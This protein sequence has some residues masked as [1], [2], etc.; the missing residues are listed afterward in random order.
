MWIGKDV[1]RTMNG[2][3]ESAQ[4]R[5]TDMLRRE[6]ALQERIAAL[7]RENTRQQSLIEWMKLRLNAVEKER[8]QLISAAIGVKVAIPEFV[9]ANTVDQMTSALNE[10][11]DLSTVGGDA[12][13]D[14]PPQSPDEPDYSQMPGYRG[15]DKSWQ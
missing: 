3:I 2:L 9:P 5:N 13:E 11:Q 1:Y 7:E 15:K 8:A 4:G 12:R 14:A 10:M 6:G